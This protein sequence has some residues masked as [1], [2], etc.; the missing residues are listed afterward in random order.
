MKRSLPNER[1][2]RISRN[3]YYACLGVGAF[4]VM[5][6]II[7]SLAGISV[8]DLSPYPCALYSNMGL[9]CP[10]CGGTRAAVY[11]MHG[12]FLQCL[13]YH[14]LVLYAAVFAGSYI[15][16]HTL[17]IVTKGKVRG[18]LF[19][20]MYLFIALGIVVANWIIKNALILIFG[21]YLLG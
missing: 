5:G 2:I 21:I 11:L 15:I 7:C 8:F 20:P 3:C 6:Y 13:I 10:G 14:P 18:M 16:S 17:H 12:R 9:Y 19:R 1:D 4:L